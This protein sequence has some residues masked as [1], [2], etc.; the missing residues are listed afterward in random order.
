MGIPETTNM[1]DMLIAISEDK[2]LNH[3]A[4]LGKLYG[5]LS[6]DLIQKLQKWGTELNSGMCLVPSPRSLDKKL[7]DK[8]S[9]RCR[10]VCLLSC[11]GAIKIYL[12]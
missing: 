9:V 6:P 4:T 10:V 8:I 3:L 11:A 2:V 7:L 12:E 5:Y 1:L